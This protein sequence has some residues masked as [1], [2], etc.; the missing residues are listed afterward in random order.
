MLSCLEHSRYL[1]D[2]SLFVSVV[3][4]DWS[5]DKTSLRP[6]PVL[7]SQFRS[8]S[9]SWSY[10][11]G[12]VICKFFLQIVKMW[13]ELFSNANNDINHFVTI[14]SR[15]LATF[16]IRL[17]GNRLVTIRGCRR[18]ILAA[19]ILS[20]SWSWLDLNILVL[21]STLLFVQKHAVDNNEYVPWAQ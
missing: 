18:L 5:Y 4:W 8:W 15:L 21:F 13:N 12:L 9:W 16:E 2:Q 17:F 7:V 14:T 6:M 19:E 3:V 11:F 20:W 10:Y 1:E